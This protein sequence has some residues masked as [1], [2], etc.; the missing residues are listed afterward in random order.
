MN[1]D[2]NAATENAG[3]SSDVAIGQARRAKLDDMRSRGLDPWPFVARDVEPIASVY[4]RF[5]ETL[6]ADAPDLEP[7][8]PEFSV[9]VAGRV[10]SRRGQGK[11]AF[12]A[13]RDRSGAER[14]GGATGDEREA[15]LAQGRIQLFVAVDASPE[16]FASLDDLD[17]GDYVRVQGQ[18]MRTRRGQLSIAPRSI[19]LLAKAFRPM[20]EKWHGLNAESRLEKRYLDLAVNDDA[21]ATFVTRSKLISAMRRFLDERGFLEVETPVL[22]PIYGGGA[23]KPFTTHH[24]E[25]GQ[26]VYLRIAVELYLKRLIV[27]GMERVYEI[28]KNFRNEG[29]SFKHN[30][31]FTMLEL[32]QAYADY[33]DMMDLF[34]QLV[35]SVAREVLGT[36]KVQFGDHE[37]DFAE[38]WPRIT[39]RQA[40]LDAC[41]IDIATATAEEMHARLVEADVHMKPVTA[42]GPIIDELFG[43]F[44]E[45]NLVQ[46]TF[47]TD[48][49]VE[50]SPFARHHRNGDAGVVERFEVVVAGMELAN[51]YSEL[52]DPDDQRSRFEQ[53]HAARSEGDDLAEQ[54]D[55]DYV[56]ALEYGM[57]PTGGLGFG[58]DRLAMLLTGSRSIR[59]V[60]L[61]PARRATAA[62]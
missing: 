40:I 36:T 19:E 52:T 42:R 27:G 11:L 21:L 6:P 37:L 3:T 29:V 26:D 30:P 33:G 48:Y 53:Q 14:A 12:L 32:Y 23:A 5:D 39:M 62:N 35:A 31:E 1:D 49:P 22:Q 55:E 46:P 24:N 41:G 15:R 47:I 50:L 44:V 25:L 9:T 45:P 59:E 4:D 20:P 2:A 38:G 34:E 8:G 57:P 7:Q 43:A 60:I 18:V 56:T 13:V 28:G 54:M 61:F 58:V 17:V 51:A 16:A 10:L